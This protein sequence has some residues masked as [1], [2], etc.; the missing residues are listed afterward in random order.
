MP[1]KKGKKKMPCPGIRENVLA[2]EKEK[3]KQN[4]KKKHVDATS[5]VTR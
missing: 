2:P 5:R 3:T 1:C 4:N